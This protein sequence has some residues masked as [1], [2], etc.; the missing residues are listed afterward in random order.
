[1]RI[2]FFLA[3]TLYLHV[4]IILYNCDANKVVINVKKIKNYKL[5]LTRAR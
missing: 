3:G 5:K 4:D 1:M 2:K